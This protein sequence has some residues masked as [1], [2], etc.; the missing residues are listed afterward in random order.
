M[1]E[2]EDTISILM[3]TDPTGLTEKDTRIDAIIAYMRN[4]RGLLEKGIKPKKAEGPKK[5]LDLA[6]LGLKKKEEG[7]VISMK[8]KW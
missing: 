4:Q 1:N 8:R 5:T 6:S 7:P 3:D 2:E